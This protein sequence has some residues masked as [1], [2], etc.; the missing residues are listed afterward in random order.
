MLFFQCLF[1]LTLTSTIAQHP[2]K[3]SLLRV[4]LLQLQTGN[5]PISTATTA[6]KDAANQGAHIAVLPSG[7]LLSNDTEGFEKLR[8]SANLLN[9]AVIITTQTSTTLKATLVDCMGKILSTHEKVK[10]RKDGV[11][12]TSTVFKAVQLTVPEIGKVGIG[13][14]LEREYEFFHGPRVLMLQGA[15]I[16]LVSGRTE[17]STSSISS[18]LLEQAS[19]QAFYTRAWENVL[20]I[21]LVNGNISHGGSC[22]YLG[23][24]DTATG[25]GQTLL[26]PTPPGSHSYLVEYNLSALRG[27]RSDAI[28]GDAFRRPFA[29]KSLCGISKPFSNTVLPIQTGGGILTIALLQ[30]SPTAS[31]LGNEEKAVT[32]I[33]EAASQG[34]EIIVMP[35]LFQLGYCSLAPNFD[36]NNV[37]EL[38]QWTDRA[39]RNGIE[40]K[41]VARFVALAK[42]LN[43]AIQVSFL[44]SSIDGGP[45]EN[46]VA[47]IDRHGDV[48][49][50]YSKVHTAVWSQCEAMTR[51][52]NQVKVATL[53][54]V[55]A[56]VVNVGSM[57]CADREFPEMP[58]MVA[59]AGAELMLIS[60][61]CDLTDWHLAMLRTRAF[62]NGVAIGMANYAAPACNGR[63]PAFGGQGEILNP[64]INGT[65]QVVLFEVNITALRIFR[66]SAEGIGRRK[67]IEQI[68]LCDPVKRDNGFERQNPLKRPAHSM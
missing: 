19:H 11:P 44:R 23:T 6:F 1:L 63:S 68:D 10:D 28:W 53:D 8:A 18:K 7:W 59:N 9:I 64:N 39:C 51:P 4:S 45:P 42:K 61:A 67:S 56:G 34:A 32:M 37:T 40:N 27:N 47:L 50:T 12:L 2:D 43:V 62:A 66:S 48:R 35:E 3:P 16:V 36:T 52:G 29:Y 54:T 46:A 38:Y 26:D 5:S 17:S 25:I 20:G 49:L 22:A 41:F 58:R 13:M 14:L 21:G 60:N 65:E 24:K 55:G 33:T 30:M 15:E 31:E 57:I